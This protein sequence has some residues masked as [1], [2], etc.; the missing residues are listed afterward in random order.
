MILTTAEAKSLLQILDNS[1]DAVLDLFIPIVESDIYTY[2][3]ND[4]MVKEYKSTAVT[5]GIIYAAND[6]KAGDTIMFDSGING[7]EPLTVLTATATQITVT[8]TLD[9]EATGNNFV[10][11]KYPKGLKIIAAQMVK[12]KI[13]Q[14]PG[15]KSESIGQYS[16]TYDQPQTG[17]PQQLW[18]ALRYSYSKYY[19]RSE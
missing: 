6:L 16:V 13:E 1:L 18:D 15:I 7:Q 5:S 12:F 8:D 9:D 3:H 4:F 2:T 14:N 10:R 19:K 17:Y 11:M